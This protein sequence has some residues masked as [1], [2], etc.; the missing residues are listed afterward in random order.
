MV[1]SEL[2]C[3]LA[4]LFLLV[5]SYRPKPVVFLRQADPGMS[6]YVM[7]MKFQKT[8]TNPDPSKD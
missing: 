7:E 3:F 4:I 5:Q 6:R 1:C 2:T 8:K